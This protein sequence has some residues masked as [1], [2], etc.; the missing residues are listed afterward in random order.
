MVI[1][2]TIPF[3]NVYVWGWL[4]ETGSPYVNGG[5]GSNPA[6]LAAVELETTTLKLEDEQQK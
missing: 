2:S 6:I 3:I 1:N 5:Q 4:Q